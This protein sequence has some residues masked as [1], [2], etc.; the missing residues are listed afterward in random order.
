M[1]LKKNLV[2]FLVFL[3]FHTMGQQNDF[4]A[5]YK[6]IAS[7]EKKGLTKDAQNLSQQI[8]ADAVKKGNEAQQIKAAMYQMKYRNMVEEDNQ[9]KNLFFADTLIAHTKAP[10]KNILQSM[11]AQLF[12]T[13]K[14]NHRYQ[15]YNR[16]ALAEEKGNDVTTWSVT[17]LNEKIASLYK[18]SLKNEA[19]LKATDL[20]GYD[21]I[22]EKGTNTRQLRPTLYDLLAHR[23]LDYFMSTENDVTN[24]SYKFII[25]EEAAFAPVRDF[26]NYN[27]KTK[28]TASL[29]L[30]ALKIMQGL[31]AFHLND[32]APEA[33]LD[34]DLK[35]LDFVNQHGVFN[36]KEKLYENALLNIETKYS[37]SS[38]SAQA[39]YLRAQLLVQS[40]NT[41]NPLS[42]KE[43]QFDL[44]KAKQICETAYAK[45][46]KSEG[47][48]NCK[49][50]I[51]EI[52]KPT[53]HF[54]TEKVNLPGQ[55]FR[56][57]IQ[58]KNAA[59][60]Y[61][62]LVKTNRDEIKRIQQN[63]EYDR[64]LPTILAL[65]AMRSWSVAMPD[66][67][68]Y[69]AHATEIKIDALPVGTYYLLASLRED[70]KQDNNIIGRLNTYISNLSYIVNNRN[71]FYVLDRDN[72][73]PIANAAVQL[74]RSNYN[75]VSRRYEETKGNLY[76]SDKNGFV[77]FA[78]AANNENENI[79]QIKYAA[80]ELFT[81]DGI[82][83]Y[84]YDDYSKNRK[85][86]KRTFLFTDRAI[87]RPGQT[88]FF[89]GIMTETDVTGR[90]SDVVTGRKTAVLFFDN[91]SQKLGSIDVTTND[92][93]S[94]NGSFKIPE[95]LLNGSFR[96]YDS[97]TSSTQYFSVE[98]YKRPKFT[99]EIKKPE[100]SYRVNDSITVT[101]ISKAYAGNNID[102]A[103]VAYRVVRIVR[104]PIWWGYYRS[105]YPPR[106]GNEEME[107]T[108]GV[109]TTDANGEFKMMFKAIPD[110]TVDRKDQPTFDY[111]VS[112][113]VTDING[114]T[115]SGTTEVSVS[116]QALQLNILSDE[117]L[118]ADSV[119]NIGISSTNANG[120]H[121]KARA[122]FTMYKLQEPAKMFRT[123]YWEQP[124]VFVMN[125]SEYYQS[126]PY[127]VYTDEDQMAKW[128]LGEKVI[129]V[130]DTTSSNSSFNI[131]H[132]SLPP[133]WYK[134]IVNA[135]DKYGEDVKAE[136]FVYIF[137]PV[138]K[139][140]LSSGEG[141]RVRSTEPITITTQ[142]NT[143][144]PGEKI[145]YNIT[146]GFD[147]IWLIQSI[148]RPNDNYK[149]TYPTVSAGATLSNEIEVTEADRGGI[150]VNYIFVQHN[151]IYTGAQNFAVPWSNK[152]LKISYETFRDKMEPGSAEKWKIKITGD[153]AEKVTA[154]TLISMYDAS[155]DQF[156]PHTWGSFNS[157]W[158]LNNSYFN[159][160]GNTFN[161]VVS[162]ENDEI[163]SVFLNALE[164]QYDY[165]VYNGW[166]KGGYS[167]RIRGNKSMSA[168]SPQLNDVAV[169]EMSVGR[170]AN[171][172]DDNMPRHMNLP[173]SQVFSKGPFAS[174]SDT[175]SFNMKT[176]T[177]SKS[178][179]P[180]AG[181]DI[182][183]RKNF[184]ETAFFF[185]DLKT[186]AGGNV[187]F[188]FTMPEA[189][190]QWKLQVMAHTKE[191]ASAVSSKTTVTQKQLMVQPN[192]PRFLREGD[193]MEFSAKIVN[194]TSSEM[195]GTSQLELLDAATNKPVDGWFKNVFPQQYF[196]VP[197]GQSVAV[198]F[199][200]DIPFNFNST[201]I[202]RI[203]AA[204][205]IPP[206]GG[207]GASDGEEA[208]IPVLTNRMLV[209]ESLPLNIRNTDSKTFKFEKLISSGSNTTLSNHALTIEFTS[210]P[211]WYAIQALP[212]LME[213]PYECAE[214]SFNRYY[215][216]TLASFIS[217]SS[218]K[219]KAVFERWK[220]T[221]TAALMSNLQKSE[222]LKA[223]LLQ[224]TPWVLN[225]Q[226]ET[227][228]KKNIALLFDMVRLAAEKNKTLAKLKEM[229][230]SNGGFTWFKGGR[231]D[232]YMTQY[233]LTGIGHLRKLKAVEGD[234]DAGLKPVIDKALPYLDA[235]LKD[236]YDDLVKYKAKLSDNHLSYTAIQYLYMR[237]FF[238]ETSIAASAR[239]AADYYKVQ[240]Q[241]YWLSQ[242]K[243]MQAMVAL[244]LYRNYDSKTAKAII[245]SL[246]QNSITNEEMGMYFKDFTKGGYYW[247]QAPIESQAM[248][249]EAFSDID[250]NENTVNDLKTWLLKQKQTQQWPTTK[251]TAE[252]CYALLM[253][254]P[255][256]P[257]KGDLGSFILEDDK[258][259]KI[260]LGNIVYSS[261]S[262]EKNLQN[263]AGSQ[264]PPSGASEAGTGYF[265]KR[266]EGEKVKPEM[267]N[268]LVEIKSSPNS[269]SGSRGASWGAAYWQ[270]FED[271]DKIT[272]AETPLKLV[273]K[274]FVE[275][276]TDKGPVLVPISIGE[277]AGGE[278]GD[279][280]KIGD[281]I[282]VR[283]ELRADRDME[284]VHMKDLR[285]ACMEPT[286]V[287]SQYKYQGGLGYY[288]STKDASTNFF[289]GWLPKGTY[290][291]E[292]SMFVTHQGNFSNG[293]TTIQCM[294]APEFT[295][296]SEGVRV[297]VN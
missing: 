246:K 183:I 162:S 142:K 37:K 235:R 208:A 181:N 233:I 198:K 238:T 212:Y 264:I 139:S 171:S 173:K 243:Y 249:I 86:T 120:L 60:V 116:Y 267:G 6:Q 137:A 220:I 72:G 205:T 94:Y 158:P 201:L 64:V 26:A 291:F 263:S 166:N 253:S 216:N 147:K 114:E 54:N 165:L 119:K 121:E 1:F 77:K 240:A 141:M 202:Y 5:V 130:T 39:T 222:E 150:N 226:N 143:T 273:K 98:E 195:T 180:F 14:E 12:L 123:R 285:A 25:N 170:D 286:N 218:P 52:Q 159:W 144:E 228:Q 276:N 102:G 109:T 149:I 284:Y 117:K 277:G 250:K 93:G 3:S 154:E 200:I 290:V 65:K 223:V 287:I 128:Q 292:Y 265:K 156:K 221:D 75:Y 135:K 4:E 84:Y 68:D 127:D 2:I 18:A 29:Y 95:G 224:E 126:F 227:Q 241:K 161:D 82:N 133:G 138:S 41:Y 7:L 91:N 20:K 79:V 58:Y 172:E 69:Q 175:I 189:L 244:A 214:Q 257:Q 289:F 259:V 184:N 104:Y 85:A 38:T 62:R 283:I 261:N 13:Y 254:S 45:F 49:N 232:R 56:S 242:S 96:L 51:S 140:S 32:A 236:E 188:S 237:S 207:G 245:E 185:P 31:L 80:D 262:E 196:T 178:E 197:P 279:E 97:L 204:T 132:S 211:A 17:K 73:Q 155:L 78:K 61:F 148:A 293:I 268:I 9:Q 190:T 43:N 255:P 282:K 99:T 90:K 168:S 101:G 157:L 186:D 217:N 251:A 191:L 24:P 113:D 209:T 28:D 112:A 55:P 258:E 105:M 88:V 76:T 199:P 225:A 169:S 187:E 106:G 115:R 30:N 44:V 163:K 89:K 234:D 63:T 294:Y 182:Q 167:I 270:Y 252:A 271:L 206:L 192:A 256:T 83:N 272:S 74:W 42:R 230:S 213:Y 19:L 203:K 33:L 153:K 8:F 53:L 111:R 124:D 134:I 21:A 280:I 193:R 210:N 11:H 71:D 107:I 40:G 260:T 36:N 110:E 70:F 27:F 131:H 23:A 281:K 145:T 16:T 66:L 22:I 118:P 67:K 296:H 269:P 194:L 108:N 278:V 239:K 103:K 48:I 297:S 92:Y 160:S 47:G 129:D 81:D 87:Y 136:K 229:Q 177:Y 10:A 274:L 146:T 151:R 219:I 266:I 100:G 174:A 164:K 288:E 50:L 125:K 275:K 57:L 248:M 231:D 46:P 35:R 122:N 152:E 34:A 247:Y 176:G 179:N 15:L 215:A 59:T 295:S